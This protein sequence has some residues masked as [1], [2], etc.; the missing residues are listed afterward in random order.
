MTAVLRQDCGSRSHRAH[1]TKDLS[2]RRQKKDMLLWQRL[3][4][5]Q[6]LPEPDQQ[7]ED[8]KVQARAVIFGTEITVLH[9]CTAPRELAPVLDHNMFASSLWFHIP[10]HGCAS[11]ACSPL[12]YG[13]QPL[14][15]A[16]HVKEYLHGF[17][18]GARRRT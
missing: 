17:A 5:C 1:G 13:F 9:D 18:P 6:A 10:C 14:H 11:S 4:D 3:H 12:E 8:S 15:E 16:P 2:Q 7:I